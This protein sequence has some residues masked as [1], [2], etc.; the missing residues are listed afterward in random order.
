KQLY[1][2]NGMWPSEPLVLVTSVSG[3]STHCTD[4][5]ANLPVGASKTPAFQNTF[6]LSSPKICQGIAKFYST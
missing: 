2:N 4:I 5:P 1:D 3:I 6:K